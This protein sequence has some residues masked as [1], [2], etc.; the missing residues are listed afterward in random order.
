MILAI[1]IPGLLCTG[2]LFDGQRAELSSELEISIGDITEAG[3]I[4]AM[5]RG[6]A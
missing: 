2:A 1:F 3:T 4:P 5:V 6:S